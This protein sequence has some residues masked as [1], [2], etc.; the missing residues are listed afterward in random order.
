MSLHD[1]SPKSLGE[2]FCRGFAAF[3]LLKRAGGE[4]EM[5]KKPDYRRFDAEKYPHLVDPENPLIQVNPSKGWVRIKK[6]VWEKS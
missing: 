2:E 1:M 5:S 6:G 4:L 3:R